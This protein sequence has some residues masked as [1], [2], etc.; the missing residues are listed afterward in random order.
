MVHRFDPV[1]LRIQQKRS[2]VARVVIPS[3]GRT[4]VAATRI[5]SGGMKRIHAIC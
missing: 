1:A 5:Q 4:V 3:A 2:V